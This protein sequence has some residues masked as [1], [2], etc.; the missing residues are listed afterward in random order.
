VSGFAEK[1]RSAHGYA[2]RFVVFAPL[3]PRSARFSSPVVAVLPQ[4]TGI[5]ALGRD[6]GLFSRT[7]FEERV[8]GRWPATV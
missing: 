5:A 6:S 8:A 3:K 4:D 7:F 2:V 1:H